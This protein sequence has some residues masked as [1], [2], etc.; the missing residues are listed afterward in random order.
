MGAHKW[1]LMNSNSH[2]EVFLTFGHIWVAHWA[3]H[4]THNLVAGQPL[5]SAAK[6][7]VGK[8]VGIST[9]MPE[10]QTDWL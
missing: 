2:K 5:L 7:K 3:E 4:S 1:S 9:S 6:V 8:T 10:L